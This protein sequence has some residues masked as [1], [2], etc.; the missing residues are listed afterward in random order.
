LKIE[1]PK[2]KKNSIHRGDGVAELRHLFRRAPTPIRS[3]PRAAFSP[4]SH[5][6]RREMPPCR[7]PHT[8]AWQKP[9]GAQLEILPKPKNVFRPTVPTV[10]SPSLQ[11]Q[12]KTASSHSF[13]A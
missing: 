9:T 4:D 3:R 11:K 13:R 5:R 7:H 6:V 10:P 12:Q 8:R 1:Q 2:E